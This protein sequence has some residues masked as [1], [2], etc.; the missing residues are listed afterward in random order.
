MT[1]EDVL[2]GVKECIGQA[3]DVAPEGIGEGQRLVGDLGADSLDLLDLTF[4][5][6][7]RFHVKISP[8]DMEKRGREKLGDK[9]W[10]VDGVLTPEALADLRANMPEVPAD[11]LK[12]GLVVDHIPRLFRVTTMVNLVCR[13]MEEKEGNG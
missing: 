3:L 4:H 12:E 8:R 7:R 11:E 1:R 6:E 13:L 10:E 5:L 9:P 2:A